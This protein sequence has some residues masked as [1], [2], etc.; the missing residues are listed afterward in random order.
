MIC[1]E[2]GKEITEATVIIHE[3]WE[4]GLEPVITYTA[5]KECYIN[6]LKEGE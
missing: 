1:S 3:K 2:C 4:K 6:M 5:H